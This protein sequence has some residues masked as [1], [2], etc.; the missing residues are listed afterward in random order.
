MVNRN[1]P[2]LFVQFLHPGVEHTPD[3]NNPHHIDW[4]RGNH[5]RKFLK[6]PGRYLDGNQQQESDLI[7]WGEWEAQSDMI[8]KLVIE[9]EAQPRYL[10]Q[11]YFSLPQTKEFLQNTDPFVFGD[12]FYYVCCRQTTKR[13]LTQLRFLGEGSV[14]L[15]GSCLNQKFVLDTVFVVDKYYDIKSLK[16]ISQDVPDTYVDVTLKHILSC[17]NINQNKCSSNQN[18]RLYVGAKFDNPKNGMFS[19]FPCL[20]YKKNI[21]KGFYR[22]VIQIPNIISDNQAQGYKYKHNCDYDIKQLWSEVKSQVEKANLNL[23]IYTELP[24]RKLPN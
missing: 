8:Q 20:P 13:G 24:L 15:F 7:F 21:S 2:V 19:F 22:P 4:N 5:K 12:N 9:E 6:N 1:N 23:G 3:G 14:I 10:F 16:Q 11:P 17:G 18:F